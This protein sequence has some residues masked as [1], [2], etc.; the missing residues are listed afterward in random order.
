MTYKDKSGENYKYN[1]CLLTGEQPTGRS[2]AEHRAVQAANTA[3]RPRRMQTVKT[4][5]DLL[6]GVREL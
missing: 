5:E 3:S 6:V 2:K 1:V 4:W